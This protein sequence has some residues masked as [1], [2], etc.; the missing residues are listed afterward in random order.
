MAMY[1]NGE[2]V[3]QDYSEALKWLLKAAEQGYAIVQCTIGLMCV[4]DKGIPQNYV[5]A[6]AWMNLAAMK[7]PVSAEGRDIFVSFM[8]EE[9]IVEG[10][11]LSKAFL[12]GNFDY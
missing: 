7:E 8:T 6:Y 11:K 12:E 2:G 9:Q 5:I 4:L 10:E 1:D 3:A